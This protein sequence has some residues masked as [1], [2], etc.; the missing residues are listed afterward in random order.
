[1][2]GVLLF[3][4][5]ALREKSNEEREK[6]KQ[7]PGSLGVQVLLPN[8]TTYL[9][10]VTGTPLILPGV[11][12][13]VP[14]AAPAEEEGEGKAEGDDENAVKEEDGKPPA[15]EDKPAEEEAVPMAEDQEMQTMSV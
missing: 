12:A 11:Q 1:M 8:P 10:A 13:P 5:V 4:C 15:E 14:V 2:L 9:A 7:S 6:L 3:L